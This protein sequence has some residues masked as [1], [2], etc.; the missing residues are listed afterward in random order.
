MVTYATTKQLPLQRGPRPSGLGQGNTYSNVTLKE[1]Y[2]LDGFICNVIGGMNLTSYTKDIFILYQYYYPRQIPLL[3]M[4]HLNIGVQ[5]F[6]LATKK[7]TGS[8]SRELLESRV[9]SED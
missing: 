6:G 8:K 1:R 7:R 2:R 3:H 4:K 9:D 5:P